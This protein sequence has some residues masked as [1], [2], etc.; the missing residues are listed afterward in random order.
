MQRFKNIVY[1]ADGV[2]SPCSALDRA[3][4]LARTNQARFTV[5]DVLPRAEPAAGLES[6][7]GMDLDAVLRERRQAQLEE[8]VADHQ[9][10]DA[11]IYTQVLT[12]NGF[13][14]LIRSVLRGDHDLVIKAAR[15]PEGVSERLFGSTDTHLLRKCPCPVWID[16]PAAATPYRSIL[17]AVDSATE[18]G[19]DPA[20]LVMD[21]ATSLAERESAR[22]QVVHA[23]R[24]Y[25][26]SMLRSGRA[27]ISAA[28]VDTLLEQSRTT[29]RDKL[30][31]LLRGYGMGVDDPNV[32]LVKGEPARRT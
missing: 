9:E 12:G 30:A 2:L 27:H 5:L 25:G 3:V 10:P 16:R 7:F 15:P 29:H 31:A 8:L 14:E 1:Y 20:R 18:E 21:L 23:W 6:R 28:E 19:A 17:A 26:E 32:H 24:L 4:T 11:V 13:L 22:I